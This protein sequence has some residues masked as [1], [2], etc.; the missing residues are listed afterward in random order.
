MPA[1]RRHRNPRILSGEMLS[2]T[3][4]P[5]A[6]RLLVSGDEAG[7]APGDR[8]FRPD[9]QGL[10]AVAVTLVV[11]FH[12]HVPGL[13]GGYVGVDVFF[14]ISG[15]VI[16][17]V[18]LRE[19]R[20]T[21]STSILSFYAR[22]VRRILPAATLV[23]IASVVASYVVVGQ[24]IGGQTATDARWASVFLINVHFAATGTNYLSSQLP[25]SVLQN[26]WSLAVEEQFYLVYPMI[27][28]AVA[29]LSQ[30]VSL[31]R[32]LSIV[33]GAAIVVSFLASIVQTSNDPTAAFFSPLPRVWELAVGA[34]VAVST[35]RLRRLPAHIAALLSWFGLGFILVAAVVFSAA[36]PYP[37][38]RVALPV[39]GA[40]MIVAGGV[41]APE[42][43]VEL[44]LRLRPFQ[45]IGLV[46]YSLYLWH[47]PLLTLAAERSP[48][49]SLSVPAALLWVLV[50]LGLAIITYL[51]IE[52]PI[53]HN[54]FLRMRRWA[55]L[56]LGACLIASTL[57]VATV[58][59]HLHEAAALATPGLATL[60]T[61]AACPAPTSQERHALMGVGPGA[62]RH[63]AARVLLIGDSTACSLLPGLEAVAAPQGVQIEDGAVIGCGIVSGQIAPQI[64]NG[65]DVNRATS[66]CS[67]RAAAVEDGAVRMGRP[68]VVIWA[69]TWERQSLVA[70][71]G[72]GQKVLALGSPQWYSYLTRRIDQ[73][74]TQLTSTGATVVMLTQPPFVPLGAHAAGP[75]A[76]DEAFERLNTLL[77]GLV[78]QLPHAKVVDL[79]SRVCPSG[80]P[81]PLTVDTV[82]A[83]GDGAHYSAE[84]GLWVA[85]WLLPQLGLPALDK[86]NNALPALTLFAGG[87]SHV[88]KGTQ[89]IAAVGAFHD[90]ITRV[91][92]Q[93]TNSMLKTAII[94]TGRFEGNLWQV[95]W[96]T[97]D[98]SNGAYVIRS[99]AFNSAGDHTLSK[100]V[101]VRV[102]N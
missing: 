82:L 3:K 18:L 15:F 8:R 70:G 76:Q 83:R 20:S 56:G 13:G 87:H 73:R 99:I 63:V 51:L 38:W 59:L 64:V 79:A 58:E 77:T 90:T 49:G 78:A 95:S 84:G 7:T 96:N 85:R 31:R 81:C 12:A 88:L 23:I 30:R 102:A 26:Y 54:A 14:V 74:V 47:W 19:R 40:A 97:T 60:S 9:V 11:L 98:V 50:S 25:P 29:G 44:L 4:V 32:R 72:A 24:V 66:V 33:L 1:P 16:T 42:Y 92:F 39:A 2:G 28:F 52:N 36:T 27:F 75:S 22:R 86:P 89:T 10:R 6:E 21:G 57:A 100:G 43:G 34:L 94:G 55:S 48:S 68:N 69:S 62:S 41:A 65:V 46:S 35:L 45:W 101:T 91:E 61:G 71:R 17:G 93:A 67:S 5:P 37:G 80:P 53:R